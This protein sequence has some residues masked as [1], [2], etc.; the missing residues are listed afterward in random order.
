M[1]KLFRINISLMVVLSA[2]FGFYLSGGLFNSE[3]LSVIFAVLLH[4]FGNSAINQVQERDIDKLMPRTM[5]RPVVTGMISPSNALVLG[6]FL[7]GLS[8]I[9]PL[10]TGHYLVA[11]LLVINLVIYNIIYTPL[12]R[13]YSYALLAG[14]LCGAIPPFV[15]WGIHHNPGSLNRIILIA[16]IFYLWQVPHFLFLTE[17]YRDEYK[18]GGI[19]IIINELGYRN[20][21]K[22][23]SVW[24][25]CYLF[26][27]IFAVA[28]LLQSGYLKIAVILIETII[29][30]MIMTFLKNKAG[31]KFTLIN[32]SILIF[33]FSFFL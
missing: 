22:I 29:I 17:K 11:L 25:L 21:Y 15:G 3:V 10:I 6:I 9:I 13:K 1:L 32:V 16:A 33:V 31:I 23:L 5:N 20:Y 2:Y 4:S 14:S 7:I 27:L 12:K 28:L 8:L 24:L 19:K 18:Y 26:A 30:I